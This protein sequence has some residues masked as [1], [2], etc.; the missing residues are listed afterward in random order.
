MGI[1]AGLKILASYFHAKQALFF[2]IDRDGSSVLHDFRLHKSGLEHDQGIR[3]GVALAT[4]FPGLHDVIN[5]QESV[6]AKYS[7]LPAQI[8]QEF[9]FLKPDAGSMVFIFPIIIE[10]GYSGCF[11]FDGIRDISAIDNE[12]KD[13]LRSTGNYFGNVLQ[14][15]INTNVV[16]ER[17]LKFSS[18]YDSIPNPILLIT[19]EHIVDCNKAALEA[20]GY[21]NK[22]ILSAIRPQLLLNLDEIFFE[23]L[24]HAV[25]NGERTD[26]ANRIDV[27]LLKQDQT[28]FEVELHLSAVEIGDDQMVLVSLWPNNSLQSENSVTSFSQ[29]DL[30][31]FLDIITEPAFLLDLH[32]NLVSINNG[33]KI[34]FSPDQV[35]DRLINLFTL[36]ILSPENVRKLN[37]LLFAVIA[38]DETRTVAL[39]SKISKLENSHLSVKPISVNCQKYAL[40]KLIAQPDLNSADSD[41][42][43]TLEIKYQVQMPKKIAPG[44]L[45]G[46]EPGFDTI[47]IV[48]DEPGL[49]ELYAT[50]LTESGYIMLTAEDGQSAL[51]IAENEEIR[52]DLLITDLNLPDM[53]GMEL[54]KRVRVAQPNVDTLLMSG[55]QR[56]AQADYPE[57][58]SELPYL[59]K[60]FMPHD[61][62][63][64]I[65][66]LQAEKFS[67]IQT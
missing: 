58:T 5:T 12:L 49:R 15:Q 3:A 24:M 36:N 51:K 60:P 13:L 64:A 55:Q 40:F 19:D 35:Y 8:R 45:S 10:N 17:E 47:L 39:V 22:T 4:D 31:Y 7:R 53:P 23:N 28:Q 52:I 11:I 20:F 38:S 9:K 54:A 26:P 33:G 27:T 30:R 34:L 29:Y 57:L 37:D 6:R 42:S 59:Q 16:L 44:L 67:S 14:R 1:V 46:D 61:L 63:A 48:E 21:E 62:L 2:D 43:S 41:K 50:L 18:I 65:D 25:Y 56:A 32:G 66:E